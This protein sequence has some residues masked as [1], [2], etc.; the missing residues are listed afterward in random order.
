MS[1]S[2]A[3]KSISRVAGADLSAKQNCFVKLDANG[4]V[5]ACSVA[6]QRAIGIL[7][8]KPAS[9]ETAEVDLLAGG[10]IA[11]VRCGG[12]ITAGAEI[13]TANDG[14]AI[15]TAVSSYACGI[16]LEAGAD[17]RVISALIFQ[18]DLSAAS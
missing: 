2:Q 13:I 17:Q 4:Q 3:T 7:R 1:T 14:E 10:G 15:T 6:G 5:V 16:A 12:N 11:K 8:N 9:G 18:G